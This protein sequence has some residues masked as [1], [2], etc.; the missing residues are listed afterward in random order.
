MY[1]GTTYNYNVGI[2]VALAFAFVWPELMLVVV[3]GGKNSFL[4]TFRGILQIRLSTIILMF[5]IL[6]Q[7]LHD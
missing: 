4:D 6:S 7:K 5:R 1:I 2:V 3:E